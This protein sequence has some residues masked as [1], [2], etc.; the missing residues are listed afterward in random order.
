[1][2]SSNR[3]LEDDFNGDSAKLLKIKKKLHIFSATNGGSVLLTKKKVAIIE[4]YTF[5]NRFVAISFSAF[6]Q[7]EATATCSTILNSEPNE[8]MS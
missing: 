5:T 3:S 8:P 4:S 1:V 6:E 2:R 7:T